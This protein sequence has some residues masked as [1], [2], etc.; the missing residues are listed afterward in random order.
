MGSGRVRTFG[1]THPF[2]AYIAAR[3]AAAYPDDRLMVVCPDEATARGIREDIE[4]FASPR[5]PGEAAAPPPAARVP[6]LDTSPY[7]DIRVDRDALAA[8]MATLF[9]LAHGA[10]L[11]APVTVMSA[12]SLIRKVIPPHIVLAMT[13]TV[14]VDSDIERDTLA[15]NLDRS[16]YAR[17]TV[18]DDPGTFA[19]RGGVLDIYSPLYRYP[20][21]IELFGDTVESIRLFDPETQRT[22]REISEVHLPPVRETILTHGLGQGES[23]DA[24]DESRA[25]TALRARILEVADAARHPSKGTRRVLEQIDNG[26]DFIGIDGLVPAFHD[27]LMPLWQQRADDPAPTRWFFVD[28]DAILRAAQDELDVA[29]ARYDARLDDNLLAFPPEAHYV[30]RDELE[31]AL[32]TL[33]PRIDAP[34]IELI[35]ESALT[36]ASAGDALRFA[37]DNNRQL[38]AEL[39]RARRLH[40]DELLEPLVKALAAWRK[41]RW[42]VAIA[43]GSGERQNKLVALLGDYE[44]P[45]A[46]RTGAEGRH[47]LDLHALDPGGL[48]MILSGSLSAGF[49]LPADRVALLSAD[50]IFGPRRRSSARQR[51]AAKR[52]RAALTGGSADFSQLALG[53]HVVHDLHGVG[54]Y[55]GLVKLPVQ[56]GTSIDFLH[57]EYRGGQLYLPVYR[58]GEVARYV[59]AEG[60]KPRLDKLG[61]ITW[62]RTRRKIAG[63]VKALAEELLQ[64]YAQRAAMP[65]H[66]YPPADSMFREFEA[67]FPFEETPDQQKAIDEVLADME[68]A[69]PMD[70]LVCG[71]VGYGKTEIALRAVMKAALGGKQAA[72]LAPTTVLVEQ[73]F[74]TM[75]ARFAGWPIE[76]ARLSRFQSRAD[77]VATIKA[78]A[79]GTV[80][81]V[82]GTHR[83]L[84][85]DVRFKDL[86]LLIIDEEQRFGVTHKER[87]KRFRTQVDVLTL[88]AT[89]IPRTLHLA[90]A[91]M[92][93][94][95]IIATP[96][97]DR[98]SVRTFVARYDDAVL[99]EGLRRELGRGGQAFFV[100]PRIADPIGPGGLSRKP[101]TGSGGKKKKRKAPVIIPAARRSLYDWAEHLRELVPEAN[102]VAAHGQMKPA[103]LEKAMVDFVAGKSHILVSTTVIENGLD[104]PRAN[105]MFV[106]NADFFG[107]SQLY[108]LRGRIGRSKERAFCY[109]LVPPLETLSSDARRRLEALQRFS[110]LGA[111]FQ[112]ASHDL[113]IRGGG[114]LL[115]AK[116]SGAIAAVGFDTYVAMLE[117]AVAELQGKESP[118]IRRARD[119]ELNIDLPGYIPDDY[120]PDT[121]QRLELYK[122]LSDAESE[123]ELKEI[124]DEITDRYGNPPHETLTLGA[125]MTL[126]VH[127][128]TLR[129]RS[130][131]LTPSRLILALD[132]DTPLGPDTIVEIVKAP[133][134]RLTPDM[135]L[136]RSFSPDEADHVV[137]SARQCLLDLV[138]YAT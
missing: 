2:A 123:D 80:D 5:D 128:R 120:I 84:S 62:T 11:C 8:R 99:R 122:R 33:E 51:K 10:P 7:A 24:I 19:V 92:K 69:R 77:Q 85:K 30:T 114:E 34:T 127:A 93:D 12:P 75:S 124:L 20:V 66:Q 83:L 47:G 134:F 17:T 97:A 133:H 1:L 107:L 60:H 125:I 95:S 118:A 56:T 98:R 110:D 50:E 58:L 52:A 27:R 113:E 71:D 22:L 68:S 31:A 32:D 111:G 61:G 41:D 116:Q 102:V 72:F 70:R 74:R 130:L 88:T 59:G 21:R 38:R 42:R 3:V 49:A 119:P 104:I 43:A 26:E 35:S 135:R 109:L 87:L 29:H 54:L 106:A 46:T 40:A 36:E 18:V 94:L 23:G 39:E 96:P 126:K 108:Q 4:L 6:G 121:S 131:E 15:R 86:G 117:E 79:A 82:V 78:L 9:R 16:G 53:D 14:R 73:H 45:V 89:P 129:A 112:V 37:V 44:V 13:E 137:E 48:P 28:P 67:M 55:R 100:C 115:G 65:G 63:A 76:V 105:T 101:P 132:D 81:V 25:R 103:E 136:A 64:I 91:G 57:L 138:S 90:M